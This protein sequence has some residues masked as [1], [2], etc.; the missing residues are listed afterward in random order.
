MKEETD[1][2]GRRKHSAMCLQKTFNL[3]LLYATDIYEHDRT[4]ADSNNEVSVTETLK[5][6]TFEFHSESFHEMI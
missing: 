4:F 3:N 1:L 2:R 6:L 5:I